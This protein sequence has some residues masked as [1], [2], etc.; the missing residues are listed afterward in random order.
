MLSVINNTFI[1]LCSIFINSFSFYRDDVP[2]VDR[3][4]HPSPA[5]SSEMSSVVP[6][7][8]D[9]S[10]AVSRAASPASSRGPSPTPEERALFYKRGPPA[11]GMSQAMSKR[12]RVSKSESDSD[13]VPDSGRV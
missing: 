5:G 11:P 6:L 9:V 8:V 4:P 3:S 2:G 13:F 7:V 12:K 10:R 1:I